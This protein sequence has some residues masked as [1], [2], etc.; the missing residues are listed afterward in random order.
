MSTTPQ[1]G[2]VMELL[3]A[4]GKTLDDVAVMA[5]V[6]PYSAR[7]YLYGERALAEKTAYAIVEAWGDS[8]RRIVSAMHRARA[9]YVESHPVAPSGK[10]RISS[11]ELKPRKRELREPPLVRDWGAERAAED[12]GERY[13][14]DEWKR[15]F[16]EP[17]SGADI[18]GRMNGCFP[19]EPDYCE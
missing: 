17:G 18:H 12:D 13:T 3:Y 4:E 9:A 5:Q 8:G 11:S 7:K 16:G 2:S 14:I 6:S 15:L 19:T 10:K 1:R